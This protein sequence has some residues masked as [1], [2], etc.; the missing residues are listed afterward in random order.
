[1][2]ACGRERPDV[3]A[4][5]DHLGISADRSILAAGI[6]HEV[7]R[8]AIVEVWLGSPPAEGMTCIYDGEYVTVCGAVLVGDAAFEK[9]VPVEIGEGTHRLRVLI[10]EV[11]SPSRVVFDFGASRRRFC[12]K[13]CP[14]AIVAADRIRWSPRSG[15]SLAFSR[16]CLASPRLLAY[17]SS[18]CCAPRASSSI[19]PPGRCCVDRSGAGLHTGSARRRGY[20]QP[21]SSVNASQT[22]SWTDTLTVIS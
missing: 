17:C 12:T 2:G 6:Q 11:G 9:H 13:A 3:P 7:D 5:L 20:W 1:V 8:E 19:T 15:R 22:R 18:T 10:D 16:P 4:V 21:A 14:S